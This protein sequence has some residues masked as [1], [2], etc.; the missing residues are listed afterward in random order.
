M[1]FSTKL[2]GLFTATI[3]LMSMVG[4]SGFP[5][6]SWTWS[7]V[8]MAQEVSSEE[9]LSEADRLLLEGVDKYNSN[10]LTEALSLYEQA[11]E[12]YRE[13]SVRQ[14]FLQ[15]SL[16]GEANSL[17][18]LGVLYN[19]QGEHDRAISY[20]AEAFKIFESLNDFSAQV[21]SLRNI[22]FYHETSGNYEL[23]IEIYS[24]AIEILK[25][26]DNKAEWVETI[27]FLA[28]AYLGMDDYMK[29]IELSKQ[30]I[31]IAQNTEY[32]REVSHSFAIL[33]ISLSYLG[34]Y[35]EAIK[36]CE[37]ALDIGFEERDFNRMS[38]SLSGLGFIYLNIGE[39][40]HAINYLEKAVENSRQTNNFRDLGSYLG[41]LGAVHLAAG[42]YQE[43]FSRFKESLEIAR[44][45]NYF[46]GVINNLI[47]LSNVY[48]EKGRYDKA[49]EYS[50]LALQALD[51]A[52]DSNLRAGA[53]T[54][55]GLL[56]ISS[57]LYSEAAEYFRI[58]LEIAVKISDK[59]LEADTRTNLGLAYHKASRFH[60]AE[61]ELSQALYL[62][63]SLRLG[64]FDS[65]LI[66]IQDKQRDAFKLLETSLVPQRKIEE[67]LV[68]TESSRA[69]A[70]VHQILLRD[71]GSTNGDQIQGNIEFANEINFPEIQQIARDTNTTLV[72]YSQ[73]FDQALYIWVIQP[74]GEIAFKE[75][76][77]EGSE[78]SALAFNPIASIDGPL[79][80]SAT[81][82][83]ELTALVN[84]SRASII[85][86]GADTDPDQLK[87]LHKV[88]IDPIADLLPTDPDA[89]VAFIPQGNLFLV[90]F[91]AL[92]DE[93]G[94]Y[95]I[96]K[97][98]ILTAPSI[99]VYGLANEASASSDRS[100]RLR[101]G[102]GTPSGVEGALIVGDP[103]M[104]TVW[105]PTA[106]GEFAETQLSPLDGAAAEAK[107]IA[108]LLRVTPLIGEQ[109][110]EARI[111]QQLPSAQLIH[112]AT[113][114]LLDYGDPRAYGTLDFPGAIALTPGDNEDGLLT[115]AEILDMN[116]QADLAVL[117]AC[118]T[119]RGR[120]TGDGVVG[121]SRSLIT[122]GVPSV[123]VS[124]WQVPDAPT[125]ELMTEFYHQHFELGLDKAQALR[126]AMRIT[127][128]K[129]PHPRN[130]A[131]FTLIGAAD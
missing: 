44:D 39:Y 100:L 107:E 47:N 24:E 61:D 34:S 45:M 27:N 65:Q 96:E 92:Q 42:Q 48:K 18:N 123:V 64:L 23:A 62:Y 93:D 33:C 75:V 71:S 95:L 28:S 88:L 116:L 3:T 112:L 111:K 126:E 101:S 36:Y 113:H 52:E 40:E 110:T 37:R 17:S 58:S 49:I 15:R 103:I 2:L 70:F 57:G 131:G 60:D 130:W 22:G 86:E 6:K 8:A 41:N 108:D 115:S 94:T 69:Q 21:T 117:S 114:G 25:E 84:D 124:L 82:D 119:G 11:L 85:V 87:E 16:R 91:A 20:Q 30:A 31:E 26:T 90:P 77:F 118:D 50:Q 32:S 120:I 73:I 68:V 105:S 97:H 59:R 89:K 83:S 7:L 76:K 38:A 125:A 29:A 80:R 46:R 4:I 51:Q 63:N 56:L 74:S 106:S 5:R 35:V 121:L 54:N 102:N 10:Q 55:V 1:H 129:Y 53:A 127:K 66:S 79:Y 109:A 99:Q 12:I 122:A 13:S 81:D 14:A 128:G 9:L 43:A 67:A 72:T 19:I 78:D 104:P 98:T